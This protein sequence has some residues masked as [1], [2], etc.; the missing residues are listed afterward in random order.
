MISMG[1]SL[2]ARWILGYPLHDW[3]GG[4]NGWKSHVIV[5]LLEQGI[6]SE[7]YAFQIELKYKALRKGFTYQEVPIVF[8]DRRV[9]QSKMSSR[10]VWEALLRVWQ[11]RNF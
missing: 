5:A 6:L 7:G 10:I 8:E 4:F 3:T 11:I 2:Y 9:G 1:G